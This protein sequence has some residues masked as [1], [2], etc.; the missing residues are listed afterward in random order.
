MDEDDEDDGQDDGDTTIPCPYCRRPIYEDSQRCP[1]CGNFISEEDA[2]AARKPWWII[3]GA[4]LAL[5]AVYR[6]IVG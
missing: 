1:H 5:Y 2:P 4:L 3:V 6:W